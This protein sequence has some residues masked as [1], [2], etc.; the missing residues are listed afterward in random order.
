MTRPDR[1]K[2]H[3]AL[4]KLLGEEGAE[5]QLLDDNADI[6]A[7]RAEF[8]ETM[9]MLDGSSPGIASVEDGRISV[10]GGTCAVRIYDPRDEPAEAAPVIAFFHGGGFMQGDLD[11]HDGI[12]RVLAREA[13]AVVVAVDYRRSPEHIYPT[14]HLDC[15]AGIDW[16]RDNAGRLGIDPK[17]L[18]LAGDSAGA[19]IAAGLL[20]SCRVK[21]AAF[22]ILFYPSTDHVSS[23]TES[24]RM[25]GKGYWL[26]NTPF[27]IRK[28]MPEA[29]MRAEPLASPA[30]ASS[31]A[32]M[33]PAYVCTIGFDPLR[34]EGNAYAQRLVAAGVNTVY[35]NYPNMLHGF[36]NCRGIVEEAER[37]LKH[38]ATAYLKQLGQ[39]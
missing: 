29:N 24:H 8:S 22:Q 33:P 15:E 12:C 9:A 34:D 13:E 3:P 28:Y 2:L 10:D 6:S 37:C 1:S 35:E 27:Y 21:D 20:A 19:T 26:D 5:A 14:A 7:L 11:S 39:G 23:E 4:L 32:E 38:A 25:F 30:L 36:L 18:C 17:T 16:I 31:L